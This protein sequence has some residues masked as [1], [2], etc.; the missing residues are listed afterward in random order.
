MKELIDSYLAGTAE[1]SSMRAER[2]PGEVAYDN[3]VL[4]ALR[5]GLSI[6]KALRLAGDKYPDESFKYDEETIKDI[7]AYYD[8]LMNHEILLEKLK[9]I[10]K[11]IERHEVIPSKNGEE[12]DQGNKPKFSKYESKDCAIVLKNLATLPLVDSSPLASFLI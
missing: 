5:K 8:D 6:D 4:T 2:T 11:A 3:E 12:L 10:E 1:F 7:K 9:Q